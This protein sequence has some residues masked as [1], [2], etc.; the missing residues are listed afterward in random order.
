MLRRGAILIPYPSMLELED[1]REELRRVDE[2]VPATAR[3]ARA[4]ATY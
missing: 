2:Y 1:E 3:G 4:H